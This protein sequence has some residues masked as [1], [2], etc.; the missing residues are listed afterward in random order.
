MACW[1]LPLQFATSIHLYSTH[2]VLPHSVPSCLTINKAHTSKCHPWESM[3]NLLHYLYYPQTQTHKCISCSCKHKI[4]AACK[5]NC[6]SSLS[7][8][9]WLTSAVHIVLPSWKHRGLIIH[10]LCKTSCSKVS[11]IRIM[12][13]KH[14]AKNEP[15]GRASLDCESKGFN[16][17][18]HVNTRSKRK[19]I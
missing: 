17:L 3:P 18:L 8:H 6:L 1:C 11:A 2:T 13:D 4:D 16:T 19:N 14:P 7:I 10:K 12:S 9:N 15:K 5:E